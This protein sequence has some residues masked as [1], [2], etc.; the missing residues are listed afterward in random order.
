MIILTGQDAIVCIMARQRDEKC[1]FAF[2]T[3]IELG[4]VRQ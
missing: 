1:W 2:Q 3:G 4:A